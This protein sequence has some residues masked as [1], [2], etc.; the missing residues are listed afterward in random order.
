MAQVKISSVGL[1]MVAAFL[2]VCVLDGGHGWM[3]GAFSLGVILY[4]GAVLG[5]YRRSGI[6]NGYASDSGVVIVF[7]GWDCV[8]PESV[9]ISWEAIIQWVHDTYICNLSTS[10][11]PS[12]LRY[13]DCEAN[14]LRIGVVTV[15]V[16]NV[17]GSSSGGGI[18]IA[19]NVVISSF[20]SLHKTLFRNT[21]L[22]VPTHHHRD[23]AQS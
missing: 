10:S 1:G 22:P 4:A 13:H 9:R 11:T 3:H 17:L 2:F 23:N 12:P 6:S 21:E 5:L 18:I 7:A 20:S 8:R 16:G 15:G 14:C 19:V